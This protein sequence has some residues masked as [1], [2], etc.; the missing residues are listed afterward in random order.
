M[1]VVV[2]NMLKTKEPEDLKRAAD[3]II[4]QTMAQSLKDL[5]SEWLPNQ[6]RGWGEQG[7][8]I[9]DQGVVWQ[10]SSYYHH[11]LNI[12]ELVTNIARQFPD[13]EFTLAQWADNDPV[14]RNFLWDGSQWVEYDDPEAEEYIEEQ[15]DCLQ[16]DNV[17]PE[18]CTYTPDEDDDEIR[19]F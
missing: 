13:I 9:D 19:P 17:A 8:D 18:N 3:Y 16:S 5:K 12:E 2:W 15:L 14:G 1:G 4:E 11:H 7:F 6:D 10:D